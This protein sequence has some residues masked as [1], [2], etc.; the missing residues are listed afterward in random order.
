MTDAVEAGDG[1]EAE[2]LARAHIETTIRQLKGHRA[3]ST[4]TAESAAVS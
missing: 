3:A 4:A 2:R 1:P